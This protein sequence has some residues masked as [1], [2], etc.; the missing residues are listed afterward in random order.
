MDG[1]FDALQRV[2]SIDVPLFS[3]AG[4]RVTAKVV[5]VYDGDTFTAVFPLP[6]DDARM[7][8]MKCRVDG[9]DTPEMK[10]PKALPNRAALVAKAYEARARLCELLTGTRG[11]AKECDD[12]ARLVEL[13]CGQFDKYGRLL[14][15]CN[16]VKET[17]INE[18]H[19]KP[20]DGGTKT[21]FVL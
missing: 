7:V 13:V 3:L 14:V 19:A 12:H 15:S 2:R 8:K 4:C 20:Y 5:E 6:G 16:D 18:G 11:G 1:S 21:S 9:V 10:P 17:L